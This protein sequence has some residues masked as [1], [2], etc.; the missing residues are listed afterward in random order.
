MV[1]GTSQ[2]AVFTV[3]AL[4]FAKVG[5]CFGDE[6]AAQNEAQKEVGEKA[7]QDADGDLDA[8]DLQNTEGRHAACE[9]D[10]EHLV[11]RGKEDGVE[12]AEREDA[13]GIERGSRR[14]EAALGER[15]ENAADERAC[16]ACFF[17]EPFCLVAALVG[18]I[19]NCAASVV[20]TQLYLTGTISAGTMLAGLLT[21]SGVGILILFR[22]NKSLREN[23]IFTAVLYTF[24]AIVGILLDLLNIG[25]LLL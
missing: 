17:D 13:C 24:G 9:H 11:R 21:G 19:P 25:A 10:G 5:V 2:N 14:G 20:I 16:I 12:R 3:A 6:G 18:L 22:T 23:L 1:E 15:A 7:E 8:E 4:G